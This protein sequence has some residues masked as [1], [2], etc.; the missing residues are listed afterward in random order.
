M[1]RTF[2]R[3]LNMAGLPW[4]HAYPHFVQTDMD[5]ATVNQLCFAELYR[6]RLAAHDLHHERTID[7]KM[8]ARPNLEHA[9]EELRRVFNARR[10]NGHAALCA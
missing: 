4:M 5:V 8:R 10:L 3:P 2:T 7:R 1:E 9:F 6:W